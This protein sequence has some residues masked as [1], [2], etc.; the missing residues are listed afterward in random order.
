MFLQ[1]KTNNS[2]PNDTILLSFNMKEKYPSV[3]ESEYEFSYTLIPLE[4][5]EE[6]L[7]GQIFCI[8]KYNDYLYIHSIVNKAI[9]IFSGDGKFVKKIP[10]GRG[11]GE[12][13]DPLYLVIDEENNQ[14]EILDFFRQIKKYTLEGDFI[15]TQECNMCS[16][17]EKIKDNYLYH[18]FTTKNQRYCFEI[19]NS[20]N[21]TNHYIDFEEVQKAP[22]MIYSHL[23]KIDTTIYF[24]TDFNNMVYKISSHNL[25]PQP[26]AT[27]VNQCMAKN[28]KSLSESDIDKYCMNQNLYINTLNFNVLHNGHTI[29]A[30]MIKEGT[31]DCFLYDIEN[32]TIYSM[33]NGIDGSI[34]GSSDN[35]Q[36]KYI[37]PGSIEYHLQAES[38]IKNKPLYNKLIDISSTIQEEDNPIIIEIEIKKRNH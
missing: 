6:C 36:Y 31:V 32:A 15:G 14:L 22:W 13:M 2:V 18:T 7:L 29:Y 37:T 16:E 34:V 25:T 38:V 33:D 21:E 5:K 20:K 3:A 1:C 35:Y 12:I 26:Y 19:N 11:P 8:K 10:V 9:M 24:H 23:F 30:E 17:F 28:I 27:I 4:T